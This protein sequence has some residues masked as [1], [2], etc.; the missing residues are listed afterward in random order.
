MTERTCMESDCDRPVQARGMCSLHYGRAWRR[1]DIPARS[2]RPRHVISNINVQD[3]TCD[4][5]ICGPGSR[6]RVRNRE[7]RPTSY[8][9]RNGDRGRRLPRPRR[10]SGRAIRVERAWAVYG[11][12]DAERAVRL[13]AQDGRCLICQEVTD[14]LVI[15]HSHEW[16]HV[17]GL[18]CRHC[19]AGLGF[20][21]DN[22]DALAR[23][24]KYVR[25]YLKVA[26]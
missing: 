6:L 5:S 23:A 1:G 4:C 25:R 18:L 16:G 13:A 15:D 19:N 9:C 20:F 3:K 14:R 22:P 24:A 2:S 12:S 17:R 21:R 11:I 8:S 26:G 10:R 7:N